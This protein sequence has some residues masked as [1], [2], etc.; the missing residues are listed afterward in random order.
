MTVAADAIG[1]PDGNKTA[2]K[3]TETATTNAYHYRNQLFS[4]PASALIYT[5]SLYVKD[6]GGG[7]I[8]LR[9]DDG[10]NNGAVVTYNVTAANAGAVITAAG[11][12]GTFTGASSTFTS[13]GNGWYRISLTVTSSATT[14]TAYV[15]EYLWNIAANSSVYT[16]STSNG[17]YVW[18]AQLEQNNKPTNYS[19]TTSATIPKATTMIDLSGNGKN[20][21]IVNAPLYGNNAL[22]FTTANT[23]V[24]IGSVTSGSDITYDVWVNPTSFPASVATILWDDNANSGGDTYININS[25]GYVYTSF[26]FVQQLASSPLTTNTWYNVTVVA[27]S[28]L[29]GWKIYINNTLSATYSSGAMG[30]RTNLS[31][32]TI[33]QGFDGSNYLFSSFPGLIGVC[34]IYNRVLTAAELQQNYNA[35]KGRYGL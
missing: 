32:I 4:K 23:S 25:S 21:T 27:D 29:P 20:G 31:Y 33:G 7:A 9:I 22:S 35:L 28:T 3:L 10:A 17:I 19:Q 5:Y 30:T 13:V 18:G 15:Q 2:D 8:G 14:T 11:T 16:G 1:A 34:K 24:R 12:Y 6:G 26:N